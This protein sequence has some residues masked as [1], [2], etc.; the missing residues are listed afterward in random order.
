MPEY[1]SQWVV[2]GGWFLGWIL[3]W[4]VPLLPRTVPVGLM[5]PVTIIIPARN[6]ALRLPGLLGPLTDG[7]SAA[8]QVIVVDDHSTDGTSDVAARYPRVRVM[9]APDLPAGWTGKTWACHTGA[10]AAPPGD[11]VFLD[12][13]V[14]LGPDA[15]ARALAMRKE[16]GGMVSIWPYHRVV[17]PYEHL[18][19]LFN[20]TTLMGI[21]AGSLLPPRT[22]RE[23]VGPMIV[24]TA[25]DYARAGGHEAVREDVLEDLRLGRR[26]ADLGIPVAVLGGGK[27][28]TFRMYGEGM[29]SLVR[30]CLRSLGRGTF[31]LSPARI[32]A[33]AV[34]LACA[35]G[36]FRWAGGLKTRPAF[37]LT[38]MFAV[39]MGVLFRQVGA[40]GW[41]DALLYPVHLVF[42]AFLFVLG[43]F[44]VRVSRRVHWRGR[45]VRMVNE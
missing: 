12:A 38:A 17:R 20:V 42:F 18:S 11:I 41:V 27:D 23:A 10:L 3:L 24:T 19:A 43:L 2:L 39:Q 21:G 6:E 29:L 28:V 8:A 1:N 40:F 7:L 30:G 36:A 5:D 31:I 45:N 33:I 44:S 25:A 9:S 22:L 13:D 34:W 37:A 35:Y 4:R 16:R 14:E 32:M 15:L 26:Y